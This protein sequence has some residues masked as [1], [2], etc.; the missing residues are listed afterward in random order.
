MRA[1]SGLVSD[2]VA[3]ISVEQ[4]LEN[5]GSMKIRAGIWLVPLLERSIISEDNPA[6]TAA[7]LSS[8]SGRAW[9][10]WG[11]GPSGG[12]PILW[13]IRTVAAFFLIFILI[14]AYSDSEGHTWTLFAVF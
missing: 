12:E 5:P 14:C 7:T 4:C 10:G 11:A 13:D 1:S 6:S 9:E 8:R 3:G 2:W